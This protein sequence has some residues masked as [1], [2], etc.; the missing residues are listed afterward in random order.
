MKRVTYL[1]NQSM[2]MSGAL[3]KATSS[4]SAAPT[5]R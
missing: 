3:P 4:R 2:A 1:P 5:K